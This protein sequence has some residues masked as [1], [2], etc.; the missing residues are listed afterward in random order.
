MPAGTLVPA[1][2]SPP[3]TV[4]LPNSGTA[5]LQS[6]AG[7]EKLTMIGTGADGNGL[8]ICN[9]M[10]LMDTSAVKGL[11]N[12]AGALSVTNNAAIQAGAAG[13]LHAQATALPV[14]LSATSRPN[15]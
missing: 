1:H 12:I 10:G 11:V 9:N 8:D 2:G 7:L 15:E 13:R 14:A 3:R 6:L 4:T 5:N